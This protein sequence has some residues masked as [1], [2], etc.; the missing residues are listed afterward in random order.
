MFQLAKMR[1]VS[2]RSSFATAAPVRSL[3]SSR[4]G[5]L[6]P[7]AVAICIDLAAVWPGA[8]Q[9]G[10]SPTP[11]T[12]PPQTQATGQP[13][14]PV[15]DQPS[16][17]HR[18]G[19]VDEIQKW[20]PSWPAIDSPRETMENLNRRA[21]DAGDN[22][23]RLSK[24]EVVSGRVK[25]PLAVNGAPD[26]KSAANRLC[27][28]AGF[29]EGRSIDSDSAEDCPASV[30]LSDKAPPAPAECRVENFVIRALCQR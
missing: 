22:L 2:E 29:K 6:L 24:Q 25:C 5:R 13:P 16:A 21:R 30:L 12:Q 15:P 20:L 26:C 11:P 4:C 19:F 28:D 10:V 8:T 23:S 14:T 18:P 3:V 17:S 1:R 7:V 27:T 9:T